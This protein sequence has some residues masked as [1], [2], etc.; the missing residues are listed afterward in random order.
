MSGI[1]EQDYKVHLKR[2][3]PDE[4]PE[5]FQQHKQVFICLV[6]GVKAFLHYNDQMLQNDKLL[7]N[8]LLSIEFPFKSI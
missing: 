1:L 3:C 6:F 2:I 7:A 5:D 8:F 4:Y